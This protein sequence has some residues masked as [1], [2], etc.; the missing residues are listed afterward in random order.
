MIL[1]VTKELRKNCPQIQRYIAL[2][3]ILLIKEKM[4]WKT[5]TQVSGILWGSTYD[6]HIQ[7]APDLHFLRVFTL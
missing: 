6:I 2:V 1:L 5:K 7:E 4:V 3:H